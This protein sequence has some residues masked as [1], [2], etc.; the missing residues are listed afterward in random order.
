MGAYPGLFGAGA[1]GKRGEVQG[2]ARK[3][4]A[5]AFAQVITHVEVGVS[6]EVSNV[7]G[8]LEFTSSSA[9]GNIS[10]TGS[11][12]HDTDHSKFKRLG[13]GGEGD[14]VFINELARYEG[15]RGASITEGICALAVNGKRAPGPVV[16]LG[17]GLRGA[18]FKDLFVLLG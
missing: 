6:R 5:K 11:G 4:D 17:D 14:V 1:G 2:N 10:C 8:G 9:A 16:I 7:G 18:G 13:G 12:A 3:G 15:D